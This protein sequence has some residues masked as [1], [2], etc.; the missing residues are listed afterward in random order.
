LG[1]ILAP[2]YKKDSNELAHHHLAIALGRAFHST[3]MILD[4]HH[5]IFARAFP[6][7]SAA[8]F[9]IQLLE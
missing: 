2:A 6:I 9:A 1:S 5:A 4:D 7:S 3:Q 8:C